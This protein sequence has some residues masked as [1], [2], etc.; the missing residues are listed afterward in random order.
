MIAL[1]FHF[2]TPLQTNFFFAVNYSLLIKIF[3]DIILFFHPLTRVDQNESLHWHASKFFIHLTLTPIKI[4]FV[5]NIWMLLMVSY[6]M[7]WMVYS[8][9]LHLLS[10]TLLWL[11]FW[12]FLI[13]LRAAC[14]D[15]RVSGVL[16]ASSCL[17][18]HFFQ[19]VH[20]LS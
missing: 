16:N 14:S 11:Y 20:L 6:A 17:T 19:F 8:F 1:L 3:L 4:L 10:F 15:F 7:Y 9:K 5:W 18:F 2:P 13:C 12:I